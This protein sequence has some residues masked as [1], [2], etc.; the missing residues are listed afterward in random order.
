[1]LAGYL[2]LRLITGGT[3]G[4]VPEAY[5][6][7]TVAIAWLIGNAVSQAKAHTR[8]LH[9]QAAAQSVATERLRIAREMHDIVAHSIGV[10]ALRAGAAVRVAET[11]PVRAREAMR[12][13]EKTGRETLSGLQ[14]MLSVLRETDQ[15][16]QVI[17]P[18]RPA[19]GL[20]DVER[21]AS[22][23]TAAGV[24]VRVQW[25]GIRP[26]PADID[27]AVFRII[28]ESVTNVVRHSGTDCCQV[29]IGY[30]ADELAIEIRDRGNS[31][32]NDIGTGYG[33][34]GMR[35][36]VALLHGDFTAGPHPARGFLVTAL[37]PAPAE[38]G[39]R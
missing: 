32:G 26:L 27:L 37:L 1:M 28:Q 35:E 29:T 14:H 16:Q 30:R 20:A 9:A 33:L 23:T 4:T 7:L 12:A 2:V 6:A 36:R 38:A 25:K 24:R 22:T 10:I 13:V 39:V 19:F 11:Q 5:L 21:L 15:E 18:L 3:V 8:Q 17:A 34:T 31:T